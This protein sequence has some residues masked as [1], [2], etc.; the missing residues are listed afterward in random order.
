MPKDDRTIAV[1]VGAPSVD[2]APALIA[3]VNRLATEPNFLFI[4]PIDPENGDALVRN[5]LA[6]IAATQNEAVLVARAG[7]ELVGLV[8]GIRGAASSISASASSPSGAAAASA[9]R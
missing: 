2:E 8:T 7:R 6:S 9:L 5:H 4:N 1:S 3:L